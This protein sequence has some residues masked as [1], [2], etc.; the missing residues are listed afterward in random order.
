MQSINLNFNSKN[1]IICSHYISDFFPTIHIAAKSIDMFTSNSITCMQ[2]IFDL[3]I[4]SSEIQLVSYLKTTE[5]NCLY[6]HEKIRY[7]I[8]NF[9]EGQNNNLHNDAV[10]QLIANK[11]PLSIFHILFLCPFTHFTYILWLV[12]DNWMSHILEHTRVYI[13]WKLY[14]SSIPIKIFRT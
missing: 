12:H 9:N 3:F 11:K 4:A 8:N 7:E 5:G 2:L 1:Y 6:Y 10:M 13:T 14:C